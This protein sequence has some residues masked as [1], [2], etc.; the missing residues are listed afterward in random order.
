MA[1]IDGWYRSGNKLICVEDNAVTAINEV[2]GNRDSVFSLDP[3]DGL[4]DCNDESVSE[5]EDLLE[6]ATNQLTNPFTEIEY[7][8]DSYE[9]ALE[10]WFPEEEEADGN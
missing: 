3:S 7:L 5:Y 4:E 10:E 1:L 6:S 9:E 8:G 2:R